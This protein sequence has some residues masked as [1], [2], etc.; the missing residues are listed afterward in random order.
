MIEIFRG[1]SM[2]KMRLV[3]LGTLAIVG[4]LLYLGVGTIWQHSLSLAN[5]HDGPTT[6][7]VA[8][9]GSWIVALL[10]LWGMKVYGRIY[11]VD[12]RWDQ[13]SELIRGRTLSY[14]GTDSLS[15]APQDVLGSRYTAGDGG[16]TLAAASTALGGSGMMV[17]APWHT[18]NVSTLPRA[19]ILDGQGEFAQPALAKQLLGV[20]LVK[21]R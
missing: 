2:V 15:F 3:M 12:L 4:F 14:F 11:V 17:N 13:K 1:Q 8:G 19:L 5:Q 10:I 7:I 9:I 21:R 20:N 18:L 6:R 16:R